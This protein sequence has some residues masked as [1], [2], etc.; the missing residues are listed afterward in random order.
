MEDYREKQEHIKTQASHISSLISSTQPCDIQQQ[1][2]ALERLWQG[3]SEAVKEKVSFLMSLVELISV[4]RSKTKLFVDWVEQVDDV[5]FGEG[6]TSPEKQRQKIKDVS[7][8]ILRS[9][10]VKL[11]TFMTSLFFQ[12][13]G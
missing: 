9:S 12:T 4:M 6:D 11:L 8:V 10:F 13:C 3:V 2:S 5:I 7:L 1:L